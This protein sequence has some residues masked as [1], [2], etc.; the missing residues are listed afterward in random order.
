MTPDK[1]EKDV[2]EFYQHMLKSTPVL[3]KFERASL[4]L[5]VKEILTQ[6]HQDLMSEVVEK[7]E[8]MKYKGEPSAY[9]SDLI[10]AAYHEHNLTIT[11][12]Q[13]IIK[14]K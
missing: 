11:E 10:W 3:D 13:T 14:S 8:G 2:E 6:Y 7:L 1:I 9:D 5:K 12:A 4:K